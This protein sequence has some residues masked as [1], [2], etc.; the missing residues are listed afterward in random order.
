MDRSPLS[1]EKLIYL[2]LEVGKA[3]Y[4]DHLGRWVCLD[5]EGAGQF[6]VSHPVRAEIDGEIREETSK[7]SFRESLILF[8]PETSVAEARV[9]LGGEPPETLPQAFPRSGM[10][11]GRGWVL[12]ATHPFIADGYEVAAEAPSKTFPQPFHREI[13]SEFPVEV[14]VT[15]DRPAQLV[16]S[17]LISDPEA[18]KKRGWRVQNISAVVELDSNDVVGKVASHLNRAHWRVSIPSDNCG[19]LLQKSYDRFH[20]RQ[21]ARVLIDGQFAGWW[22][23][24]SQDRA[25]RWWKT[26]FG[27]PAEMTRGKSEI[28]I[29][30]DPPGGVPLWSVSSYE[31]FALLPQ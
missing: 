26:S 17:F 13:E 30:I 29:T 18:L 25:S 10:I 9:Y 8:A 2:M 22:Y 23:E 19:L 27:I 1:T 6:V 24:A 16:D 20:G 28:E 14:V 31:L 7:G 5:V 3:I 15:N 21:R 12:A 4:R 11:Q